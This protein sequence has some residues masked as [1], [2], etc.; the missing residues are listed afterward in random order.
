MHRAAARTRFRPLAPPPRPQVRHMF[1]P[2]LSI[3]PQDISGSWSICCKSISRGAP[4]RTFARRVKTYR[5]SDRF[6]IC[7]TGICTRI[8]PMRHTPTASNDKPFGN[9]DQL[10]LGGGGEQLRASPAGVLSDFSRDGA[11]MAGQVVRIHRHPEETWMDFVRRRA[12]Q[13]QT[14][15]DSQHHRGFG[16]QALLNLANYI[17]HDLRHEATWTDRM[18]HCTPAY[19]ETAGIM[20]GRPTKH[21]HRHDRG[22][23]T[24]QLDDQQIETPA[25]E[26]R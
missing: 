9:L 26:P 14:H 8:P 19:D 16:E 15:A 1:D 25:V 5:T 20:R 10:R 3:L 12:Q 18:M 17:G 13:V 23:E 6:G 22:E 11:P 7:G 4:E 21:E 2:L 24:R